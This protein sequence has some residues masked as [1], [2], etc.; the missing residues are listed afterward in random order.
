MALIKCIECGK[1][2]SDKAE[3]C[4]NCGYPTDAS[5][6]QAELKKIEE[7]YE[8]REKE[9]KNVKKK[10]KSKRELIILIIVLVIAI[11]ALTLY[12]TVFKGGK[13]SKDSNKDYKIDNAL[14]C[15]SRDSFGAGS[16]K[17]EFFF[18]GEKMIKITEFFITNCNYYPTDDP[19]FPD[20]ANNSYGYDD[21]LVDNNVGFIKRVMD[22]V[23][24]PSQAHSLVSLKDIRANDSPKDVK[25]KLVKYDCEKKDNLEESKNEIVPAK[26]RLEE[27]LK[28]Y[29][30]E[31]KNGT[32]YTLDY[33]N[34][35]YVMNYSLNLSNKTYRSYQ[36]SKGVETTIVYNL[37]TK[38]IDL[39]FVE[40]HEK[41]KSTISWDLNTGNYN[42]N[43]TQ[44]NWCNKYAQEFVEVTI[45]NTLTT[46]EQLQNRA[47]VFPSEF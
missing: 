34:G 39:T 37:K 35:D 8:K 26:D 1:E 15:Y 17:L 27:A 13:S 3:T 23:S 5:I 22:V 25:D 6:E 44:N 24:N 10:K 40:P 11:I 36:K 33:S 28:R 42:C 41:Y 45:K 18:S 32:E 2:I 7:K 47:Q 38:V 46:F 4:P 30:Y 43:S 14:V 20:C 21:Y 31:T 19:R 12:F 29:G 9:I 16:Y